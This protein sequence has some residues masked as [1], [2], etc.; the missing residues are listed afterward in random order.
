MQKLSL[1]ARSEELVRAWVKDFIVGL[2][3][4]PFARKALETG[5]IRFAAYPHTSFELLLE[6]IASELQRLN[7]NPE[8]ETSIL[9]LSEAAKEFD[10]YLELLELAN[11]LLVALNLEGIF[12]LASFHPRYIFADTTDDEA[13]NFTNRSPLPLIHILRESSVEFAVAKF[14]DTA[15]IPKRNIALMNQKGINQLQ[16]VLANFKP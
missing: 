15:N 4:C 14:P 12:Q 6:V 16:T 11:E 13:E 7:A 5:N 1:E 2:N 8:I 10:E 9:I 3:L